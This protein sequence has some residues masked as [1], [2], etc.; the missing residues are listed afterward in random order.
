[1]EW[2]F[3]NSFK[4]IYPEEL[5]LNEKNSDN[6]ETT[7]LNLKIKIE[8]GKF[9]LALF[10]KRDKFPFSIVRIANKSSN[11]PSYMFYSAIRGRNFAHCKSN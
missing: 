9:I 4:E 1:M 10:N 7:F 5:Q 2:G 11:L 8:Y 6:F 3:Q